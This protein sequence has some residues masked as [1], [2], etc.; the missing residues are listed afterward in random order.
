MHKC[1]YDKWNGK[2]I[3]RKKLNPDHV[4]DAGVGG[5]LKEKNL[6][7]MHG[8]ANQ[9]L[10]RNMSGYKPSEHPGGIKAPKACNCS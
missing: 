5:S 3:S 1:R 6:L 9:E 10:G 7:W 8:E 2:P 4:K